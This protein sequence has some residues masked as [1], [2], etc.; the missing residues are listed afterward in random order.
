MRIA[1]SFGRSSLTS[2]TLVPALA[3][4]T[5]CGGGT[6]TDDA[7]VLPDAGSSPDTGAMIDAFVAADA[8][9]PTD[10]PAAPDAVHL[11]PDAFA[12]VDAT[13]PT[14]PTYSYVV[15]VIAADP[16]TMGETAGVNVDGRDSGRGGRVG[17]CEERR[18]D[19][20]S[21]VTGLPGIDNQ[22]SNSLLSTL[23]SMGV[24]INMNLETAI[25]EG[26]FL[27]LVTVDDIDDFVDD[28]DGVMVTIAL[29][30][31]VSGAPPATDS[32]T[33]LLTPGQSFRRTMMLG[34]GPATL[35]GNRVIAHVDRIPI[36][37]VL[38]GTET[39]DLTNSQLSARISSTE[40]FD[41]EGGG[42]LSVEALVAFA[43]SNGFGDVAMA[44][45]PMFADLQPTEADPT[46]CLAISA[47]F[48][49]QAVS[50]TVTP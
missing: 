38:G 19:F 22:L 2:T 30:Q 20:V 4:L 50:A 27:L 15:S 33:G 14:M 34:S 37:L 35:T 31:T 16:V 6:G 43:A 28:P 44:I 8:P 17:T 48:R 39:A 46:E 9:S 18:P 36:P 13:P 21:S 47:G 32:R 42:G 45:L 26:T 12:S 24:D 49:M 3:L 1:P 40:L 29:G 10:A 41:G 7:A 23:T 25:T 11:A 5:A